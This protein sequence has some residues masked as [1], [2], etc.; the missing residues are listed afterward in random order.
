MKGIKSILL[1]LSAIFGLITAGFPQYNTAIGKVTIASPNAAALGKYG[2]IPVNYHTGIPNI[3]IPIYTV[4]SGP[5]E[6]PI[7]LSYHASGLKVQEQASWV[8]AGWCLNAGGVITRTVVGAPDDKGLYALATNKGHFSDYGYNSYLFGPG[9]AFCAASP[10]VCPVGRSGMTPG[11]APQDS[12]LQTGIFDGEPDLFFFNFNGHSGKFYFNDDRTPIIVPEM[13]LKIVPIYTG[14]DWRGFSGFVIT[15]PDG[16]QYYFGQNP[17]TDS[18]IDATEET[19]NVTTQNNS[20]TGQGA[21]SSWFLN[22]ILS[23]D[24]QFAI[25]LIY[26]AENYSYY[27]LSMYP[28]PSVRNPNIFAYNLEYDLDKNFINGVRLSKILF[29]NGEVDFNPGSLRQDLSL[30]TQYTGIDDQPNVSSGLGGRTLG[31]ISINTGNFCKKDSFFFGYFYD[32][33]PLTG[34]LLTT[35]DPNLNLQSDQYRLR[36]DSVQEFSCDHSLQLPP[37]KFNYFSGT[38]PRKLSFGIDHWGFYNGVTTNTG[39]IPTYMII[40]AA[41]QS[42]PITTVSGADRD[43]HWPACLAGTLQQITYPTGGNSSFVFESNDVYTTSTSYSTAELANLAL[44]QYGQEET[45]DYQTFTTNGNAISISIT[46]KY[47]YT[48]N[49]VI[50][51]SSG[52]VYSTEVGNNS[53]Y[54]TTVALPA[55]TYTAT[56]TIPTYQQTD[57]GVTALLTE[58]AINTTVGN[59]PIGGL[60]I[61]SITHSDAITSQPI[62]TSYRSILLNELIKS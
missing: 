33:S 41:G 13:D 21:S 31:S 48:T 35:G 16:V 52:T 57:S 39:L 47:T 40:P 54:Q 56:I 32:N 27:T 9:P 24:G 36:L 15:T 42:D 7:S 20:Y 6:L 38:V 14:S 59:L 28:I 23:V 51:N 50:T 3:D 22:K 12:Y 34:S 26:Q 10:Y 8:G 25:N 11:D 5:L 30:G 43:T 45:S 62:L 60:R 37:Y 44:A 29:S 58:P 19:Y 55:G 4:K 18:N 61:Q 49:L 53:S 17:N 2:D 46:N 1:L